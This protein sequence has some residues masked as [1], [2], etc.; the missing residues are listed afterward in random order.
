HTERVPWAPRSSPIRGILVATAAIATLLAP[1][2]DAAD[3]TIG[4]NLAGS[5]DMNI[6]AGG[7][8]CTYVQTSGGAPV[9]VSPV[10]GTV[11]RWP[12]KAG[13]TSGTV[14][15]RVLRPA[16]TGFTAVTSSVVQTVTSAMNTFST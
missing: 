7:I 11:L 10:D 12:L 16:G 9:A 3:V 8:S 13:S 2:A 4:S 5:A 15:L 14:R 1:A 6:C